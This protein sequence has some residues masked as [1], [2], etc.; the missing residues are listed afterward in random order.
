MSPSLHLGLIL[1]LAS[2]QTPSPALTADAAVNTDAV[3]VWPFIT[4]PPRI[5]VGSK[6][7][8]GWNQTGKQK[9]LR[10]PSAGLS[11]I[12][13]QLG[14]RTKTFMAVLSAGVRIR[15][16][17]GGGMHG[18]VPPGPSL[19]S[20]PT[21]PICGRVLTNEFAC[22][23]PDLT[24][25]PQWVSRAYR[26][27]HAVDLRV[28]MHSFFSPDEL[29]HDLLPTAPGLYTI[30]PDGGVSYDSSFGG[31]VAM[32]NSCEQLAL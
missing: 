24:A 2:H 29:V 11:E 5:L 28:C 19:E 14:N 25:A 30:N 21:G 17:T 32:P 13:V 9:E 20:A 6:E 31:S 8:A 10:L 16:S 26:L 3:L 18:D 27:K 1:L 12:R 23:C 15:L 4:P 7:R 22:G